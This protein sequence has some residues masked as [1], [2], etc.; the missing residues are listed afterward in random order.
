MFW[1]RKPTCRLCPSAVLALF[2]LMCVWKEIWVVCGAISFVYFMFSPNIFWDL[3]SFNWPF[4]S[5]VVWRNIWHLWWMSSLI[6]KLSFSW[7]HSSSTMVYIVMIILKKAKLKKA[8]VILRC[9]GDES[10]QCKELAHNFCQ[11]F[12]S[13]CTIIMIRLWFIPN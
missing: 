9:Y 10:F 5:R 13:W 4:L 1:A 2:S 6:W 7:N 12:C 11:L 3:G 8:S